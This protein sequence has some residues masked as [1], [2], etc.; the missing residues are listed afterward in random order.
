MSTDLEKRLEGKP[1]DVVAK[2][3]NR[4]IE[5]GAKSEFADWIRI[6]LREHR[7]TAQAFLD[8]GQLSDT[9]TVIAVLG[10]MRAIS[11]L[12]DAFF[13]PLTTEKED[14]NA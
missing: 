2:E 12:E 14:T 6:H 11:A 10:A 4:I 8:R 9:N 7:Q 5:E 1:N 13:S 3:V